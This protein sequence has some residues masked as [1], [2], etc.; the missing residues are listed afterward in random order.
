MT[1]FKPG[2]RALV[3]AE[4][5]GHPHVDG[6]IPVWFQ[7]GHEQHLRIYVIPHLINPLPTDAAKLRAAADVLRATPW[8]VTDEGKTADTSL[9]AAILDVTA[10]RLEAAAAPKP[11]LRE[12]AE[13]AA[14]QFE[15][16][17]RQH[18]AK[19]TEDATAKAEVNKVWAADIRAALAREVAQS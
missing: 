10:D 1:Q 8:F 12:V 4:I 3:E 16:Y 6:C 18:R 15:F 13:R 17:E 7:S 19:G 9:A 5:E 14:E 2:D 11:T